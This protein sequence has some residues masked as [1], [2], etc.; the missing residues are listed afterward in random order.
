MPSIPTS[1]SDSDS[2]Y[3][4]PPEYYTRKRLMP[5]FEVLKS[6]QKQNSNK[7][8]AVCTPLPSSQLDSS[9]PS[10]STSGSVHQLPSSDV[11]FHGNPVGTS[12]ELSRGGNSLCFAFC[13]N[14]T[15]IE[16]KLKVMWKGT[17]SSMSGIS[18]WHKCLTLIQNLVCYFDPYNLFISTL[19][20]ANNKRRTLPKLNLI[21][22][23]QPLPM[24]H[25]TTPHAMDDNDMHDL[26]GFPEPS[27]PSSDQDGMFSRSVL[28]KMKILFKNKHPFR[29]NS[30]TP[31][32]VESRRE[33]RSG[34][35]ICLL[36]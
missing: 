7:E 28:L 29:N 16:I 24:S 27:S 31:P 32:H 36:A 22:I 25:R 12:R 34:I 10:D 9:L 2:S 11:T 5:S 30:V 1:S 21:P 19:Y 33:F 17:Q 23:T 8:P 26:D 14:I 15:S 3:E 4:L 35:Q 6:Q 13:H 20:P 18:I